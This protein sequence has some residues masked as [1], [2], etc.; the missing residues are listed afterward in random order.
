[1]IKS[2]SRTRD[3]IPIAR[4]LTSKD[5]LRDPTNHC[6]PL[7]D[8]L[9]DPNDSS[10]AMM[11]MKYLRPFDKP[12]FRTIGEVVE[13]ISQTLEVRGIYKLMLLQADVNT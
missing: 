1:M 11:V 2:V 8:V 5:M 12:E 7:F 9:D 3:E 10:K 4:F 13:F 6:V